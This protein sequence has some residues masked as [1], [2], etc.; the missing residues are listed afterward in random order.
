M[1]NCIVGAVLLQ[2][3]TLVGWPIKACIFVC[4]P[5]QLFA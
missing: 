2:V 4:V 1:R 5:S 3:D